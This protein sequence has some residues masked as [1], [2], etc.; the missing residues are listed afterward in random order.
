VTPAPSRQTEASIEKNASFFRDN[1]TSYSNHVDALDTYRNI[2][3]FTDAALRGMDRLLDIGN[4]GTFD[5]DV[6][7]VRELVAVDLFL[8]ELPASH[9]PPNVV[10][11][12]GTALNLLEPDA[13]FDGVIISM[14]IHH[15]VGKTLSESK[16]NIFRALAEAFRVLKPGGRLV[17]IESCVPAWFY[18]FER[19]VFPVASR[20]I[21]RFM[22]H[23][24][25]LQFPAVIISEFLKSHS[26][27]VEV[28]AIPKGSWIL[29]YGVKFPALLTPA[30]PYRFVAYKP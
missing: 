18:G 29:Q 17:I 15:L 23:P 1:V 4:G 13:S 16:D 21:G 28:A 26:A 27:A 14:L 9:F 3:A 22:E 20:L 30:A 10:P 6:A 19:L 7:Q 2:R 25:T 8:E 12:N 24:P 5:Y 11:K